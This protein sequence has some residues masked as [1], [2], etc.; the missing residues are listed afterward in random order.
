MTGGSH[1]RDQ[2]PD[3]RELACTDELVANVFLIVPEA[4]FERFG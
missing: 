4:Y 3:R 2:V 1:S